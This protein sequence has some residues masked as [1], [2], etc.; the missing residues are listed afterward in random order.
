MNKACA[1]AGMIGTVLILAILIRVGFFMGMDG[2]DAVAYNWYS[3]QIATGS[4]EP[5]RHTMALRYALLLPIAL[6]MKLFGV[7]EW[8]SALPSFLYGLATIIVTYLLALK[9]GGKKIAFVALILSSFIPMNVFSS[10]DLH[11]DL[12]MALFQAISIMVLIDPLASRDRNG[13]QNPWV[14]ALSGSLVGIAYLCKT[15]GA[16]MLCAIVPMAAVRSGIRMSLFIVIGFLSVFCA[17]SL[18]Y[19]LYTGDP[20]YHLTTIL[21]HGYRDAVVDYE[22]SKEAYVWMLD[23]PRMIVDPRVFGFERLIATPLLA[24][25]AFLVAIKEKNRP[26]V[27]IGCWLVGLFLVVNFLPLNASF[28]HPIFVRAHWDLQFICIP[29]VLLTSFFLVRCR[30]RFGSLSLSLFLIF[31]VAISLLSSYVS[32]LDAR[33]RVSNLRQAV[34]FINQNPNAFFLSDMRS[35][36][37]LDYFLAYKRP[38]KDFRDFHFPIAAKGDIYLVR[39]D[40][41][42]EFA[43]AGYQY[44]VPAWVNQIFSS[45]HP[46]WTSVGFR[47]FRLRSLIGLGAPYKDV[48][49]ATIHHVPLNAS[50][51]P[52]TPA[53][54]EQ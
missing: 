3:Y 20:F 28:T 26:F 16:F 34:S 52:Q 23:L 46:V 12:P 25:I 36:D 43:T 35:K 54:A 40:F 32:H 49:P 31:F 45:V 48:A 15:P 11:L 53:S 8:S 41:W 29:A 21:W 47:R 27:L 9:L 39:D 4:Y 18:F 14:F 2:N 17:E 6:S 30:D 33:S 37:I 10:S 13:R 19:L 42:I 5:V 1:G 51:Q 24:L 7:N 44:E 22:K 38:T 50:S